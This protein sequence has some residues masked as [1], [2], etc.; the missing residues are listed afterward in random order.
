VDEPVN[1]S[2]SRTWPRTPEAAVGSV[3]RHPPVDYQIA[4]SFLITT[5]RICS[6]L[7]PDPRGCGGLAAVRC[8]LAR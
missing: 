5:R 8:T 3:C 4:T 6:Q 2:R 1:R 7:G